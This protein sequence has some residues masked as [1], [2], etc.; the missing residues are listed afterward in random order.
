M[1]LTQL[2]IHILNHDLLGSNYLLFNYIFALSLKKLDLRPA[3]VCRIQ[4]FKF[5]LPFKLS[6]PRLLF[7]KKLYF[8]DVILG[9]RF[10]FFID[11]N[12]LSQN[13]I[14]LLQR[15]YERIYIGEL[16]EFFAFLGCLYHVLPSESVFLLKFLL[17]LG[18]LF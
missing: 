7:Q 3:F 8:S 2:V 10:L 5:V 13:T 16:F 15:I 12:L 18:L 4:I 14:L 1:L 6:L 11:H 17:L 9:W